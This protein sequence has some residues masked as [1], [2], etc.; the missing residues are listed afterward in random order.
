MHIDLTKIRTFVISGNPVR[1]DFIIS[2]LAKTG[3]TPEFVEGIKVD[4]GIIGCGLSH[5]KIL[6]E[7]TPTP[8]L[9]LEDD[10]SVT[11]WFQPTMDIPN[12]TDCVYLGVS[13][14]GVVPEAP[15]VGTNF[16]TTSTWFNETFLR[17]KNMC[18]S[19]AILYT[20]SA[21]VQTA[22][23]AILRGILD[24]TPFDVE[25]AKLQE[26]YLALTPR[27]PLFKQDARVGG[28]E[29]ATSSPLIPQASL[30]R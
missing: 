28:H 24:G 9:V 11:E 27:K 8:F 2:Q 14:W 12:Y 19:H 5:A 22:R 26:K 30:V 13:T 10:C 3:I 15:T 21:F 1:R 23:E 25:L 4:P 18:S 20:S 16:A 6:S 7:K 29:T 17:L